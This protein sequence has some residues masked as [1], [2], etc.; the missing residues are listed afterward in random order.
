MNQYSLSMYES[1]DESDDEKYWTVSTTKRGEQ[2][3]NVFGAFGDVEGENSES[4]PPAKT[5]GTTK[6]GQQSGN[7]FGALDDEEE[8]DDDASYQPVEAPEMLSMPMKGA[9]QS[10]GVSSR[11]IESPLQAAD[12]EHSGFLKIALPLRSLAHLFCPGQAVVYDNRMAV[13]WTSPKHCPVNGLIVQIKI[14][15]G[16]EGNSVKHLN[17]DVSIYDLRRCFFNGTMVVDTKNSSGSSRGQVAGIESNYMTYASIPV[18]QIVKG[19]SAKLELVHIDRL[20]K[21]SEFEMRSKSSIFANEMKR[22]PRIFSSPRE[23]DEVNFH[24]PICECS[25]SCR[26]IQSID[27]VISLEGTGMFRLKWT[28]YSGSEVQTSFVL[29]SGQQFQIKSTAP[30]PSKAPE[31]LKEKKKEPKKAAPKPLQAAKEMNPYPLP[32]QSQ[33]TS[34]TLNRLFCQDQTVLIDC[35]MPAIITSLDTFSLLATVDADTYLLPGHQDL[36]E[37]VIPVHRLRRCF[38]SGDLVVDLNDPSNRIGQVVENTS[39]RPSKLDLVKISLFDHVNRLWT[40]VVSVNLDHLVRFTGP[41][42]NELLYRPRFSNFP[43]Y[44]DEVPFNHGGMYH[45]YTVQCIVSLL[46][47][48]MFLLK[49]VRSNNNFP[50]P[51]VY[52]SADTFDL[53]VFMRSGSGS[54]VGSVTTQVEHVA[55]EQAGLTS[56]PQQ[57]NQKQK[58]KQRQQRLRQQL[59]SQQQRLPHQEGDEGRD[60]EEEHTIPAPPL[61]LPQQA[62]SQPQQQPPP[63]QPQPEPELT[64]KQ[65]PPQSLP[66]PQPHQKEAVAVELDQMDPDE[67]DDDDDT[68]LDEK[69][70]DPTTT[71]KKKKNKKKKKKK[72]NSAQVEKD[73]AVDRQSELR[74]TVQKIR[75]LCANDNING[76]GGEAAAVQWKDAATGLSAI[77]FVV[78]A[79]A[80][81]LS[82]E[83]KRD[84]IVQLDALG[85]DVNAPFAD[86]PGSCLLYAVSKNDKDLVTVLLSPG[87]KTQIVGKE[88]FSQYTDVT[89]NNEILE[90]LRAARTKEKQQKKR[91]MEKQRKERKNAA[92]MQSSE[93]HEEDEIESGM[94]ALDVTDSSDNKVVEVELTPSERRV[95]FVL[96]VVS[97]LA[98]FREVDG[99]KAATIDPETLHR[100]DTVENARE[101]EAAEVE[102][103]EEEEKEFESE[104]AEEMVEVKLDDVRNSADVEKPS[105]L[106][107][108]VL[109]IGTISEASRVSGDQSSVACRGSSRSRDDKLFRVEN[110]SNDVWEIEIT[111]EA[112]QQWHE[113]SD[114]LRRSVARKI[115][116]LAQG[117]WTRQKR[118]TQHTDTGVHIY[119]TNFSKGGRILWERAI[120]YSARLN[121]Y[122]E[123]IRVWAIAA[124]HDKQTAMI[125]KIVNSHRKGSRSRLQVQ[126][127]LQLHRSLCAPTVRDSDGN[128]LTLPQVFSQTPL[129]LDTSHSK[130]SGMTSSYIWYP[131]AAPSADEYVL[132]KFYEFSRS[133][134]A[135]Y[136]ADSSDA[137]QAALQELPFRLSPT[138][139]EVCSLQ[140][141][142]PSSILL[143]GRSGTGKTTC[144]VFRL[145]AR[146]KAWLDFSRGNGN[147]PESGED[148][149]PFHQLFLTANSVLRSEVRHFFNN[150]RR[151]DASV[152]RNEERQSALECGLDFPSLKNVPSNRFPLF[153]TTRE[154]LVLLDGTLANPFFARKSL[155]DEAELTPSAATRAW[156]RKE[157]AGLMQII[158]LED[159]EDDDYDEDG[160]EEDAKH[161]AKRV[162]PS[163]GGS[164]GIGGGKSDLPSPHSPSRDVEVDYEYF[165]INLWPRISKKA[166]VKCSAALLWAEMQSFIKGSYES[167]RGGHLSLE[168]YK[169]IGIKRAPSF[170]GNREEIYELY[171]QYEREKKLLNG[172]DRCDI[173][174][175]IYNEIRASAG[176]R[177]R[178]SE[179]S[180]GY[181]GV[182][183]HEVYIDEVQD[184]LECELLLIAVIANPNHMFLTGDTAQTIA[185]GLSFRFVDVYSIF[186][187]L[188]QINAAVNVP[189]DIKKL[190]HNYRTHAGILNL[191]NAIVEVILTLFPYSIDK[192]E[193]DFGLF[194]GPKP[195][196]LQTVSFD[197]LCFLLLGSVRGSSIE[198]GANQAIIVRDSDSKA[199]I[200]PELRNA[201]ILC[202]VFESKGLEFNDVLIYNFMTDSAAGDAW[203]VLLGMIDNADVNATQPLRQEERHSHSGLTSTAIDHAGK[204]KRQRPPLQFDAKLH[205]I[206]LDELR[207][208]Y[209]AVTRAR[210]NVWIYDENVEKRDA[211]FRF[212]Q[213][214]DLVRVASKV[215]ELHEL[216]ITDGMRTSPEEWLAQGNNLFRKGAFALAEF[217]FK[218]ANEA[219]LTALARANFLARTEPP[220]GE[221]EKEKTERYLSAGDQFLLSRLP[222]DKK[223]VGVAEAAYCYRKAGQPSLAARLY[224]ALRRYGAAARCF[225]EA[226]EFVEAGAV[227]LTGQKV[228]RALL[229]FRQC[230][231]KGARSKAIE[232][233]LAADLVKEAMSCLQSF[234]CFQEALQLLE[235][236]PSRFS[237]MTHLRSDLLIGA[238]RSSLTELRSNPSS[239]EGESVVEREVLVWATQ[240]DGA[241]FDAVVEVVKSCQRHHLLISLYKLLGRYDEALQVF[242]DREHYSEGA[243]F[244][245]SLKGD[246]HKELL[247]ALPKLLAATRCRWEEASVAFD[248]VGNEVERRIAEMES[249]HV[250]ISSSSATSLMMMNTPQ[251][252][253]KLLHRVC[254][255][256]RAFLS[257]QNLWGALMAMQLWCEVGSE[258]GSGQGFESAEQTCLL[259]NALKFILSNHDKG[260]KEVRE[261]TMEFFGLQNSDV[262][263]LHVRVERLSSFR[264]QFIAFGPRNPPSPPS[265]T[266]GILEE[267]YSPAAFKLRPEAAPSHHLSIP[268]ELLFKRLKEKVLATVFEVLKP[269]VRHL[270][271]SV[272]EK[273]FLP[274]AIDRS[275]RSAL[276]AASSM[277]LELEKL[278]HKD[279]A[280]IQETRTEFMKI[281]KAAATQFLFRKIDES[282]EPFQAREMPSDMR[283]LVLIALSEKDCFDTFARNLTTGG[284]A[285]PVSLAA[286]S[287]MDLLDETK[288]EKE[289]LTKIVENCRKSAFIPAGEG[290]VPR[291]VVDSRP[292]SCFHR[293][294]GLGKALA[295]AT[296]ISPS[297]LSSLEETVSIILM[298]LASTCSAPFILPKSLAFFRLGD[299]NKWKRYLE[300]ATAKSDKV[301]GN[302][303]KEKKGDKSYIEHVLASIKFY[304]SNLIASGPVS[305]AMET[306]FHALAHCLYVLGTTTTATNQYDLKGT[307]SRLYN[308]LCIVLL[309]SLMITIQYWRWPTEDSYLIHSRLQ[310]FIE[311][312]VNDHMQHKLGGHVYGCGYGYGF[313]PI[314]SFIK[315]VSVEE[316]RA[317]AG[318]LIALF[319][320]AKDPLTLFNLTRKDGIIQLDNVKAVEPFIVRD[321]SHSAFSTNLFSSSASRGKK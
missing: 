101:V 297:A 82:L 44:G 318:S 276:A 247:K 201:G 34:S 284:G 252:T 306:G 90:I 61:P 285:R 198:F 258:R 274:V 208:L 291:W 321:L 257:S 41:L 288:V 231:S 197:H 219:R 85:C 43:R 102:E 137:A 4:K 94:Q 38:Y 115:D 253:K 149:A 153:V 287:L 205:R 151:S 242:I 96:T 114:V 120:S 237:S 272:V 156:G 134:L 26:C 260:K 184:F 131:P 112:R 209:T 166:A 12:D 45:A 158:D 58:Q 127:Q 51:Y 315:K 40:E 281:A 267:P 254:V 163:S 204:T 160:E 157:G 93:G 136:C 16:C 217:C 250:S 126:L 147:A 289:K 152:H 60:E 6:H 21:L 226:N 89:E 49:A 309:N 194:D 35:E 256:L 65:A 167:M 233:L 129:A 243:D 308:I 83:E 32:S 301:A 142:K 52:C 30:P 98:L 141:P 13:I 110:L 133:H 187:K 234:E 212:L 95:A 122:A 246:P 113:L 77:Q 103:E 176:R 37:A 193:P 296:C 270:L 105:I 143:I 111:K 302:V 225:K 74:C 132:L 196:L 18:L 316:H 8:E 191:A 88:G 22:Q 317:Y 128:K 1:D 182:S 7:V 255:H 261:K 76:S 10:M 295:T 78:V 319:Q 92:R 279:H 170:D 31:L 33:T 175:H 214:K 199:R 28:K 84:L 117:L 148:E 75:E 165:T 100:G 305:Q 312:I 5:V 259:M 62:V 104:P 300:E 17:K 251:E 273:V 185:R 118:D 229:C 303:Q 320:E 135:R 64:P 206:L 36:T 47:E 124:D 106:I 174:Y 155:S 230:T 286:F 222:E 236:R 218:K 221:T 238:I 244:L 15:F 24:K 248:A 14:I 278:H 188:N 223:C 280:E 107:Q 211:L 123:V 91:L 265:H 245:Q 310:R 53:G 55:M 161:S 121:A 268:R 172:F 239:A 109:T 69:E 144:L 162:T 202:S 29:A 73:P 283:R 181:T 57:R 192:L 159:G 87:L 3:R 54:G 71:K 63:P 59:Q 213:A 81:V 150:L 86:G 25:Q 299:I 68:D 179:A 269:R 262:N 146:Y 227:F 2:S 27:S 266:P 180:N 190:T 119:R 224:Q 80:D 56:P 263:T 50:P 277:V 125:H 72:K 313:L 307:A 292:S 178:E 293:V 207:H 294:I 282:S 314:S 48:G 177:E 311:Y 241:Y 210:V 139:H 42:R 290:I 195:W 240:L 108:R 11:A 19:R 173:T 46:G 154:F 203:R 20:A 183:I 138:E 304:A 220:Q 130:P 99:D 228:R 39:Q 200:R 271:D 216:K 171:L 116:R 140:T 249:M 186:W 232:T 97:E 169:S 66:Q 189:Q 145:W 9:T 264:L 235:A 298:S 70:K 275:T 164:G 168:E 23:G 215:T 79:E 67:G